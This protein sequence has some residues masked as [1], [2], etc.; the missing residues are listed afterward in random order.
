[1]PN[2]FEV[3]NNRMQYI[4]RQCCK[5]QILY[6]RTSLR[7]KCIS[8]IG[9]KYWNGLPNFITELNSVKVFKSEI[10]KL[11]IEKYHE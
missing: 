1:M 10:K 5:F 9:P 7:A 6:S 4:T 8:I 3:G 2:V 11:I